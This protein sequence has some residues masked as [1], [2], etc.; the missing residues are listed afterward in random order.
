MNLQYLALPNGHWLYT[1][2]LKIFVQIADTVGNLR[3]GE[4]TLYTIMS[5]GIYWRC[6]FIIYCWPYPRN[7]TSR[8]WLSLV[9]VLFLPSIQCLPDC[10]SYQTGRLC[11]WPTHNTEAEIF[12]EAPDYSTG[13]DAESA[14]FSNHLCTDR[15]LHRQ[16]RRT[17][18][19]RQ[20]R[21]ITQI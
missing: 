21:W 16:R 19:Y 9:L 11:T 2:T 7:Y 4:Q 1:G 17:Q 3:K 5:S 18:L 10:L 6:K 14:T 8:T 13:G 12:S 20:R 15:G